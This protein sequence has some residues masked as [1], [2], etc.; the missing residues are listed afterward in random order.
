LFKIMLQMYKVFMNDKPIILI[1]CFEKGKNYEVFNFDEVNIRAISL[2]LEKEENK[3]IYLF[4]KKLEKDWK[5]FLKNFNVIEAAGGK[6]LNSNSE[7]LFIY[8]FDRWDLPK[9]HI[10]NNEDKVEAAIREVEEECG[11]D[12]LE[13]LEELE[14]TYHIFSYKNQL[15]L[16]VTYW[17]LMRTLFIGELIPQLEEGIT[18][19]VFKG[20][21]EIKEALENTYKNIKLLF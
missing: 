19:V 13:V 7:V 9:G 17:Y 1:D 12:S 20:K 10:E 21:E 3:G 11:I 4:S 5:Q 14:T 18:K 6:V 16:K 8:R 2:F 15:R